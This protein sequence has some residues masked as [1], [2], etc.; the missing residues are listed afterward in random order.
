MLLQ[1]TIR[2]IVS[3][4]VLI[5]VQSHGRNFDSLVLCLYPAQVLSAT[6]RWKTT[7]VEFI[8]ISQPYL[9]TSCT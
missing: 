1:G 3:L 7:V 8:G 4:M 6:S 5:A 2:T 9:R